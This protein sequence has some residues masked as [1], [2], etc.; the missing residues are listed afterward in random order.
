M[1]NCA[2]S[3]RYWKILLYGSIFGMIGAVIEHV[4]TAWLE[5][6]GDEGKVKFLL[7]INNNEETSWLYDYGAGEHLNS[8]KEILDNYTEEKTELR[9]V[10]K[11][12]I[13]GIELAKTS[14]KTLTESVDATFYANE[15]NEVQVTGN[16]EIKGNYQK[17]K[18]RFGIAEWVTT[19]SKTYPN[20]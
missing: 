1:Y 2:G 8:N 12:I 7:N 5:I 14:V 4:G 3:G 19:T 6:F 9:Y 15:H 17:K 20:I 10:T 11:D 16:F 13:S 18:K